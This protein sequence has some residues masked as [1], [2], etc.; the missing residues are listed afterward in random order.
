MHRPACNNHF[1]ALCLSV[2]DTY[3]KQ[4]CL[5]FNYIYTVQHNNGKPMPKWWLSMLST[6][7]IKRTINYRASLTDKTQYKYKRHFKAPRQQRG[8]FFT[9]SLYLP[10]Y[11]LHSSPLR[12]THLQ[13]AADIL[14]GHGMCYL[15]GCSTTHSYCNC[16][17]YRTF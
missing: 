9:F 6:G 12:C 11:I 13:Q 15:S 1:I 16:A 4:R 7:W 8:A 10:P 17:F 14:H 5:Q 2:T 3:I